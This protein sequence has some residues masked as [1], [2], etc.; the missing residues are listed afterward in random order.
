M[1]KRQQFVLPGIR[2]EVYNSKHGR[3]PSGTKSNG[4]RDPV[5]KA[6]RQKDSGKENSELGAEQN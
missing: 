5:C 2:L 1:Y 4:K 3:N 6:N